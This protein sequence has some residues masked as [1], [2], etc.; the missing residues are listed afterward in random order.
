MSDVISIKELL[1]GVKVEWKSLGEVIKLKKGKQLNKEFLSENGVYP[2]YNGG[3]S[4]SGFT[5]S[6]NYD[7]NTIIIS[8]GGASAGFV[9]FVTTKFYANAH[10][11]VIL[12][13]ESIVEN[14]YVYHFLKLNQ[15]KLTNKQHGAGI[16]ALRTSE[17]IDIE[18]PIPPLYVQ[19]EI[20]RI[21]DN[22]TELTAELTA[23]KKQ[24]SYYRDTLLTFEDGQVEFKPLGE[25]G[26][27]KRGVAFTKKQA[28]FG[29][30][31]VVANAIEPISFHNELNRNGEFIVI[32]RSGA[33]AGLISYWNEELFLTDAFS[34]HSNDSVLNTKFTYYFLKKN[35]RKIHLMK[36]G[37]G[38][39][40]VRASDFEI[41]KI[42]VPSL[43]EQ[44]RIVT[45][46]DKFDTLTNSISEGLPKEI[47]LRQKQYKYYRD[48][49]L[50]FPKLEVEA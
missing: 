18:I 8:Q 46:L 2:A 35:Q 38:V 45:I 25:V 17:I 19:S 36:R 37:V 41:Y 30:Y 39:P 44:E 1:E 20:V 16:P 23:R 10:C 7:E 33:N 21:L 27:I 48:M 40:H 24:Y 3:V 11:Y 14:R 26:E 9:N 4:Y 15:E 47:E 43:E 34:I 31:P 22:F 29:K 28:V 42:P 12:P 13:K 5:D 49:L 32:A 50:N 6:F